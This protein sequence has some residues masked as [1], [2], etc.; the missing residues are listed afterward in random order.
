MAKINAVNVLEIIDPNTANVSIRS[1]TD[2]EE[3]NREAEALMFE[4]AK[5]NGYI[6]SA[7]NA[8]EFMDD[9]GDS[10]SNSGNYTVLITHS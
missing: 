2:D 6:G 10:W 8:D 7:Q 9:E 4:C 1:F 5:E 3:G